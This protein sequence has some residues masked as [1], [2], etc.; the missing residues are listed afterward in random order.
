MGAVRKRESLACQLENGTETID[1]IQSK[2]VIHICNVRR[3]WHR[4]RGRI[5]ING[6]RRIRPCFCDFRH[7]LL[8]LC[9]AKEP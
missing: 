7:S 6:N 5:V 1:D 9:S 3:D 4:V 2:Y 8:S